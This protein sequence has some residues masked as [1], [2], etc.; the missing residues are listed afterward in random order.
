MFDVN[1]LET[2]EY[3]ARE[4]LC[5]NLTV[6]WMF[7]NMNKERSLVY[8]PTTVMTSDIKCLRKKSTMRS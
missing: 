8:T 4:Y 5:N 6:V 7:V 1:R 3:G 2:K